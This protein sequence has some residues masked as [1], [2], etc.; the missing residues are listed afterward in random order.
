VAN[1]TSPSFLF[2]LSPTAV[3]SLRWSP[4]YSV[5]SLVLMAFCRGHLVK[6]NMWTAPQ[7]LK[8]SKDSLEKEVKPIEK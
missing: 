4:N 5:Y 1:E 6:M 2:I 7:C 3:P 8:K